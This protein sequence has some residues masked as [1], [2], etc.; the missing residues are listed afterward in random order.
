[1]RKALSGNTRASLRGLGQRL[2]RQGRRLAAALGLLALGCAGPATTQTVEDLHVDGTTLTLGI[3]GLFVTSATSTLTN[4]QLEIGTETFSPAD[5][6]RV[7]NDTITW[8][9]STSPLT[10]G[11]DVSVALTTTV[12][13]GASRTIPA[14]DLESGGEDLSGALGD[15]AGKWRLTVD[16]D[17]PI[18]VMSLL[19]SPTGHL[20]NLSTAPDRGGT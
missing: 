16:S 2:A 9:V 6:T 19:S 11:T 5:G 13:A 15:G 12:P 3:D 17:E 1:M 8:T 14:A 10:D 20:T 7:D 18:A 4:W